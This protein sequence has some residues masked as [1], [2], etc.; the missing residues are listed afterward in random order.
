MRKKRK[1]RCFKMKLST[2]KKRTTIIG[3]LLMA[4][5]LLTGTYAFQQFNQGA[6]NPAWDD[7]SLNNDNLWDNI[8]YGGRIHHV[9]EISGG[10][11]SNAQGSG[12]FNKDIFAENFRNEEI[13]VRVQLREFLSIDGVPIGSADITNPMTW[14]VYLSAPG[15]A[16]TR[17]IG[18]PTYDIGD[19]GIVWTMGQASGVTKVFMPTFNRATLPAPSINPTVPAPFNHNQ[20][21]AFADTTGRAVDARAAGFDITTVTDAEDIYQ[22]GTQTGVGNPAGLHDYWTV[23][24]THNAIGIVSHPV[25]GE[26]LE[27]G[28]RTNTAQA[29]LTPTH[30]DGIM[31]IAEWIAAGRP[32]GNFWILDTDGWFYWHGTLPAGQATSLLLDSI[33]LPARVEPWE[34]VIYVD[35]DFFTFNTVDDLNP[36]PTP[37]MGVEIDALNPW[38]YSIEFNTP[39]ELIF[40]TYLPSYTLAHGGVTVTRTRGNVTETVTTLTPTFAITPVVAEITTTATEVTATITDVERT[41]NLVASVTPPT[42]PM[43][44]ATRAVRVMPILPP[45]HIYR[46]STGTDW[47]ILVPADDPFGGIGN[48]L[49]I[50]Y[51]VHMLNQQYH[52]VLGFTRFYNTDARTNINNWFDDNAIVSQELR[53]KALLYDFQDPTQT[54]PDVRVPWNSPLVGAGIEVNRVD[55]ATNNVGNAVPVATDVDRA[56]TRPVAGSA[57][58]GMPFVLS[59]SEANRHFDGPAGIANGYRVAYRHDIPSATAVWWLR[60]PGFSTSATNSLRHAVVGTNGSINSGSAAHAGTTW[61]LRP[62]LWV[63]VTP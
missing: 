47:L 40:H 26:L 50:T 10:A 17:R 51:H 6:F 1:E 20:A 31:T 39:E 48:Q 62:A 52:N 37:E 46:D 45:A 4:V 43:I 33:E 32:T 57:G 27:V 60:P 13:M 58:L 61:G 34:Y 24:T 25:S 7:F 49:M 44:T 8:E 22:D 54:N 16:R 19:E 30:G 63:S 56:I 59:T 23:G 28:T 21:F 55:N 14:P 11:I 9:F 5:I 42:G 15:N 18:T 12:N 53:D 2:M 35:A 29:T 41:A 36:A 3:L 38:T